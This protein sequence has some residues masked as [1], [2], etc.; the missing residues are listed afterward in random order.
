MDIKIKKLSPDLIEDYIYFHKHVAF[1]DNSEWSGCYCVWYHW[2]WKLDLARKEYENNGGKEFKLELAKRYITEDKLR[3]YLAYVD[4]KVIGW[5]NANERQN[6]TKLS[7][8]ERPDLWK[9]HNG[10][11]V[12]SIICFTIAP[13]M[14]RKGLTSVILS[15]I[16]KDAKKDGFDYVEAYPGTGKSNDRSYHGTSSIYDKVGFQRL[17]EDKGIC[18]KYLK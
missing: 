3:G 17:V 10:E 16:L 8:D 12:K 15:E 14:R 11:K 9:D 6:Y 13:N 1:K 4:G 18:R 5:C 2:N 7:F